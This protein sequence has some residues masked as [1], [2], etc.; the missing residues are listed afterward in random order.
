MKI[1]ESRVY[2]GPNLYALWPVIRLRVDLGEL[3]WFPTG[4]L[5]GFASRLSAAVPSLAEHRCSLGEPGGFLRRITEDDGTWLGHVLEHIALELQ[6]LAGT[7][8]GF[9]KT[10]SSGLP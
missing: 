8:V 4:K 6:C 2:R 9:G 5:P 3:E 7:P 10:R 1:L